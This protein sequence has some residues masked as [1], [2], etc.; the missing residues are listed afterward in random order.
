M[1]VEIGSMEFK[2]VDSIQCKQLSIGLPKKFI[3]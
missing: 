1:R 3:K 2:G